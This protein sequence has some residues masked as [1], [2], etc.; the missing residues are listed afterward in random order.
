MVSSSIL[1]FLPKAMKARILDR[2][3]TGL[4]AAN[5]GLE[6]VGSGITSAI[7]TEEQLLPDFLPP[8]GGA[9]KRMEIKDNKLDVW[10]SA[11][12]DLGPMD[13]GEDND[14]EEKLKSFIKKELDF[15]YGPNHIAAI[16]P[17]CE[18]EK[19]DIILLV[20]IS[21]LSGLLF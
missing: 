7:K 14:A 13:D 1:V 20:T 16:N 3:A 12:M 2:V 15:S 8:K 11:A 10:K 18:S 9:R 6:S 21:G 19:S 5:Q 17:V 4:D